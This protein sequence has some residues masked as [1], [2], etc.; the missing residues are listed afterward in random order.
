MRKTE[1]RNNVM[2]DPETYEALREVMRFLRDRYPVQTV[3]RLVWAEEERIERL[4]GSTKGK[5]VADVGENRD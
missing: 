2:L 4:N 5:E 1:K 3:R